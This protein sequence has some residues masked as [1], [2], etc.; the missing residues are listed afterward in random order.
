MQ[1]TILKTTVSNVFKVKGV[2]TFLLRLL[3]LK[4]K[5]TKVLLTFVHKHKTIYHFCKHLLH[6]FM[7]H[8]L[9]IRDCLSA[10][11]I[12]VALSDMQDINQ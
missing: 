1:E 5:E 10:K 4:R 11:K 8:R 3:I 7:T 12:P 9:Y 6:L 2:T